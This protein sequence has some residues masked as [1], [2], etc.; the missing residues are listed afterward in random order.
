[1]M[2]EQDVQI[3]TADGLADAVVI[4]P[5]AVGRWPG[6]M[7]LTDTFGLREAHRQVARRLAGAGYAVVLPN[8][9][10]RSGRPPFFEAPIAFSAPETQTRAAELRATLTPDV[11]ER[12]AAGYVD[13]VTRRLDLIAP[14]PV[15]VVGYCFSGA[16][17]LRIAATRPEAFAAAASFHGGRL[18]TDDAN[19]P[20][21]L[22]PRITARL[23]F[24]HARNDRSMPAEAIDKLEA[25]LAAWGGRFESE[26]YDAGHGWTV[27]DHPAYNQSQ[28][29]HAFNTLS[30]LLAHTLIQ[31]LGAS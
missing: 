4:A 15:A 16:I 21:L 14:A 31:R 19:S 22:L 23:Y 30:E 1:M 13:F 18:A 8:V 7:M 10:Y 27:P 28:A 24:G 26:I 5:A 9:F 17:A 6:V 20:H 11:I 29:E 2:V 12:D 3:Q 25:A